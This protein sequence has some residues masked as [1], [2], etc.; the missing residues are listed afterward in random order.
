VSS[1]ALATVSHHQRAVRSWLDSRRALGAGGRLFCT[2]AGGPLSDNYVRGLVR[3]LGARAG[4]SKRVRQHGPPAHLRRRARWHPGDRDQQAARSLQRL[5]HRPVP[6]RNSLTGNNC[7][8][9]A[10]WCATGAAI[11][12]QVIAFIRALAQMV[13][14]VAVSLITVSLARATLAE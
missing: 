8:H 3:R 4:V 14:A 12:H 6:G 13:F 1:V 9:F 5:G 7:E 11:S 2:V 10:N